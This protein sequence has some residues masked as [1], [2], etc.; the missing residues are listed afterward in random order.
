MARGHVVRTG[1]QPRLLKTGFHR[2]NARRLIAWD[3]LGLPGVSDRMEDT[4]IITALAQ[5]VVDNVE[6][7]I[8]GKRREVEMTLISLLCEGH[9]LIED[10]PG[11]AQE[12]VAVQS[13][14]RDGDILHIVFSKGAQADFQIHIAPGLAVLRLVRL[15]ADRPVL[16]FQLFGLPVPVETDALARSAPLKP[17]AFCGRD[18]GRTE[19]GSGSAQCEP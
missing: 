15:S 12:T 19:C 3:S 6:Q 2:Y 10:V 4:Q 8:I 9:L 16:R 7:V 18:A 1:V 13:V 14:S 11:T 5:R 17:I